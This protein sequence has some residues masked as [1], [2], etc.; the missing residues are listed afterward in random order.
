MDLKQSVVDL[1]RYLVGPK[2]KAVDHTDQLVFL[3]RTGG[4]EVESVDL[5]Y[6]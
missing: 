1:N 5:N 4:P 3:K 2:W 6:N